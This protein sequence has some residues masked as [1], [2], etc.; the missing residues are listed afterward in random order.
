VALPTNQESFEPSQIWDGE[1]IAN[2]NV[3]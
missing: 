1:I 2:S 3:T